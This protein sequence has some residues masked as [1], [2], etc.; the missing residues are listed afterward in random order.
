MC[1]RPSVAASLKFR[2]RHS[3]LYCVCLHDAQNTGT[4]LYRLDMMPGLE[5]GMAPAE[6]V[7]ATLRRREMGCI[8]LGTLNRI[9]CITLPVLK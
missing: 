5:A 6:V 7:I 3:T 2:P 8:N 4:S 9:P 1:L